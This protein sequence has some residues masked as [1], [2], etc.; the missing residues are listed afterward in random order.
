[1]KKTICGITGKPFDCKNCKAIGG[2]RNVCPCWEMDD[3]VN[4]IAKFIREQVENE[5]KGKR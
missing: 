1:M 4:K 3:V 2:Q 5:Q